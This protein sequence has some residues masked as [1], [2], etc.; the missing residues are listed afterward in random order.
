[1]L[2]LYV[3]KELST[4]SL[5]TT[6]ETTQEK[7]A[8]V[9]EYKGKKYAKPW[10]EMGVDEDEEIFKNALKLLRSTEE[11]CVP[12]ADE[13]AQKYKKT[14]PRVMR[15]YDKL[16]ELIKMSAFLHQK[17]RPAFELETSGGI[18]KFMDLARA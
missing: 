4:R 13:L 6:P 9:L 2:L 18:K 11:V 3:L 12:Y 17:Q 8:E 5:L 15:D 14:E 1:M 16:M 10:L 7:I